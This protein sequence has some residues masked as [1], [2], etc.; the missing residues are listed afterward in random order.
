[1][2][3]LSHEVDQFSGSGHVLANLSDEGGDCYS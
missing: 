1:M 2:N 3:R